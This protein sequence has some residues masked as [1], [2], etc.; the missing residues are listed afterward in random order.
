MVGRGRPIGYALH[1]AQ[2]DQNIGKRVL[3]SDSRL[4]AQFGSF[5]TEGD[6]L[7]ENALCGCALAIDPLIQQVMEVRGR[8]GYAPGV[9]EKERLLHAGVKP[10]RRKCV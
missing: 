6:G 8:E 7:T 4:V 2:V 1:G 5:D 9:P 10:E 3:V